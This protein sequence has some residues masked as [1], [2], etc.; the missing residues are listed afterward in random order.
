MSMQFTWGVEFI[1]VLHLEYFSLCFVLI[2]TL[3]SQ[4]DQPIMS[5]LNVELKC[6]EAKFRKVQ[7]LMIFSSFFSCSRC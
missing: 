6:K 7:F 5:S 4:G 1:L 3:C 2:G